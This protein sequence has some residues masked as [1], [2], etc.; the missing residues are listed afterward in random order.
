MSPGFNNGRTDGWGC[1]EAQR[2]V[3]LESC[4]ELEH[5]ASRVL[6]AVCLLDC[7]WQ[8]NLCEEVRMHEADAMN[9]W[10]MT[11]WYF[12]SAFPHVPR[13]TVEI[14]AGFLTCRDAL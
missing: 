10:K 8:A 5:C 9:R 12:Q 3:E 7:K 1:I 14:K 6:S 11:I 4:I 2:V 13:R